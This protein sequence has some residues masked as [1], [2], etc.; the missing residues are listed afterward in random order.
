MGS[1]LVTNNILYNSGVKFAGKKS[2]SKKRMDTDEVLTVKNINKMKQLAVQDAVKGE[3]SHAAAMFKH[4]IREKVAPDRKRIFAEAEKNAPKEF[5]KA[6]DERPHELW[7]YL[8]GIADEPEDSP[9]NGKYCSD[10]GCIEALD[11][12]GNVCGRYSSGSGWQIVYTPEEEKIMNFLGKV[13]NDTFMEVYRAAHGKSNNSA[14][15]SGAMS[16]LDVR[17]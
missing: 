14:D 3:R 2:S 17:V 10:C 9:V 6:K 5:K 15:Y 4:H 11:E 13:Y 7:E 8:L 12:K 16:L 1:G